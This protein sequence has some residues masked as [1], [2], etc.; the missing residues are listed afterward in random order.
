MASSKIE[1]QRTKTN[2][3]PTIGRPCQRC[4]RKGGS[5]NHLSSTL[6]YLKQPAPF[7]CIVVGTG[8]C[9][10]IKSASRNM[11]GA[12]RTPL[13]SAHN[14]KRNRPTDIPRLSR[15]SQRKKSSQRARRVSLSLQLLASLAT[16]CHGCHYYP[17]IMSCS[18]R[19]ARVFFCIGVWRFVCLCVC[20]FSSSS[21]LFF[22]F[23]SRRR[24]PRSPRS[25]AR[26]ACRGSAGTA[27]ARRAP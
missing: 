1:A 4:Q 21:S 17:Y 10:S 27:T 8:R 23:R 19:A 20:A 7:V 15:S 14:E 26:T 25:G 22:V 12:R 16:V 2:N 6:A 13:P 5:T 3:I 18:K 9:A 24:P 11:W